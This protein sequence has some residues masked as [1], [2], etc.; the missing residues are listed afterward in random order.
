MVVGVTFP[1]CISLFLLPRNWCSFVRSRLVTYSTACKTEKY[2]VKSQELCPEGAPE[3]QKIMYRMA[4]NPVYQVKQKVITSL[5]WKCCPGYMGKNCEH[6]GEITETHQKQEA[7]LVDLQNDIHQ[8]ATNLG[9]L[10]KALQPNDSSTS[11]E[12][13][14]RH[15]GAYAQGQF[16]LHPLLPHM[17]SFLKE[18]LNPVWASF[19]KSLQELS[20]ALRN[21]SQNV[22]ANRKSIER[23]QESTV[24]KKDLQELGAKF[25]SKVQ[26]NLLRADQMKR[27]IESHLHLQQAAIHYN[28]TS[29]K[30][31]TDM[32]LKRHHKMQHSQWS[33]LNSSLTGLRQEQHKL[34]RELEAL[35][36]NLAVQFGSPKEAFT[37][38]EVQ[39]VNQTLARHAEQ[40]KEL[41]EASDED[42]EEL[43][44][45]IEALKANSKHEMEE[46]RVDLMEKSL[47]IEEN[48][49]DQERKILALNHTLANIQ[50]SHQ[51]LQRYVKA[52]HCESLPSG[53][54]KEDQENITQINREEMK[55]LE[56]RLKDL[57]AA[58][59]LMHQ[60]LHFQ[61]EQSRKLEVATSLLKSHTETLSE[62]ISILQRND[63]KIHGH[64]KYLNS[65]FNSLLLDAMRHEKALEALLGEETMEVL[66]EDDPDALLPSL[67]VMTV[68]LISDSLQKQS[69]NLESLM[70][71]IDTLEMDY[72]NNANTHESLEHSVLKKQ[73]KDALQEVSTQPSRVEDMEP[74]H[75]ASIEDALDNPA[76]H[77]LMTL[78]KEIGN[79]SR[80]MKK[81]TLQWDRT[82]SCCNQTKAD[83]VETLSISVENL[84][85]D[86]AL[87]QQNV[88]EH[89]QIFQKLFGSQKELA[90][91]NVT[92][93]VA[94][95]QLLMGRRLRKQLKG[96]ERQKRKDPK[97]PGD[98]R[99][100][101]LNGR[102][103]IHTEIPE[104][105]TAV[106]F[107][108]R[109]PEE[110]EDVPHFS[111]MH[112]NYGKGYFPE[113]GYFKAPHN[114]VY[115]VAVNMD[116]PPAPALGRLALSNGKRMILMGNKKRKANGGSLTNFVLVELKRGEHMWFEL[117]QGAAVTQNPAGLS[118][119]G[120]LIFK[121]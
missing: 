8:A 95:I 116:L 103:K 81:N 98:H 52:C 112:L 41:F 89:L 96:Q 11:G 115:M 2:I 93:D 46:L 17:E 104:T 57:T 13:S 110:R 49:V 48:R 66:L 19:N 29:I 7:L 51:E 78:K 90:A 3:C 4:L 76:Y 121:T 25:E 67:Q 118:M 101:D 62:N 91:A 86:L 31:D 53:V 68:G 108:V 69:K 33:A 58:F 20:L 30:A 15:P 106:A 87:I 5:H 71:R 74:N 120:F 40:L 56:A 1:S 119:A 50:E 107:Y 97:E 26:A 9:V 16:L 12:R 18:H 38:A 47:I 59:P 82:L 32:K 83:L 54:D 109:Y 61:Q 105:G 55:Q 114:A 28:L 94:K 27:D 43:T 60:S 79:L 37:V 10:Q 102:N 39:I 70:K 45:A 6:H 85:E 88:E 73:V 77:D 21:L 36:G 100:V 34:Q 42:Y 35:N 84:R 44:N 64:I 117:V 23:F 99:E 65:S 14:H 24:P 63:E 75:E 92:L 22:E 72:K 111:G 80:E 113:Q